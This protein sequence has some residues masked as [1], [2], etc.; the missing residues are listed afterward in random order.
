MSDPS[1][2]QI[3]TYL[4]K[5][6]DPPLLSKY[7]SYVENV[8]KGHNVSIPPADD[9]R[10]SRFLVEIGVIF[11][12]LTGKSVVMLTHALY[13]TKQAEQMQMS[14]TICLNH[15]FGTRPVDMNIY[16]PVVGSTPVHEPSTLVLAHGVRPSFHDE[17]HYVYQDLGSNWD[18]IIRT[19]MGGCIY[20]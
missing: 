8:L 9:L 3:I 12:Y 2:D 4:D 16:V 11:A 13:W 15:K 18:G 19:T 5:G 1:L 14:V 6:N 20:D 7:R 17:Q 10:L